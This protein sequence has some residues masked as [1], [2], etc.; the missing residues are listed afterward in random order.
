MSQI[1]KLSQN[2]QQVLQRIVYRTVG[3]TLLNGASHRRGTGVGPPWCSPMTDD[4]RTGT[5]ARIG[6]SR[7]F[8][9]ASSAGKAVAATRATE[10][11]PY[12]QSS[13]TPPHQLAHLGPA[14]RRSSSIANVLRRGLTGKKT[15]DGS[16]S[17]IVLPKEGKTR[18]SITYPGSDRRGLTGNAPGKSSRHKQKGKGSTQNL[19][20]FGT[21]SKG[22]S[23]S[24]MDVKYP[25]FV[26]PVRKVLEFEAFPSHQDLLQQQVLIK[27]QRSKHTD[28]VIFVSH[29]WAGK[30]HPDPSSTQLRCLQR[31]LTRMIA[32]DI[33]AVSTAF[34]QTVLFKTPPLA[35]NEFLGEKVSSMYLWI[36]S[37]RR[38]TSGGRRPAFS[39]I[40]DV[41]YLIA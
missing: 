39:P 15:Q 41:R 27:F 8:H 9:V 18:T 20:S 29:Q 32:G 4:E 17:E 26:I 38:D 34:R 1:P 25:M 10:I 37:T 24:S 28:A 16:S 23:V 11:A 33:K 12:G 40:H 3:K 30:D 21:P 36:V 2:R 6:L 31:T 5:T 7:S 22:R 14:L 35:N 13:R 19:G